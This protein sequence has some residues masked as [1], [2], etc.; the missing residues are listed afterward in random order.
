MCARS[1]NIAQ[2]PTLYTWRFVRGPNYAAGQEEVLGEVSDVTA[3]RRKAAGVLLLSHESLQSDETACPF[4][5]FLVPLSPIPFLCA[6][7]RPRTVGSAKYHLLC[8]TELN[9]VVKWCM[10][11]ESSHVSG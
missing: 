2:H 11:L 10:W 5:S 1:G 8:F 4:V 3:Y 9:V 7:G 6:Q